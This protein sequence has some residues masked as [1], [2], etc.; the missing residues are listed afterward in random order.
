ME[1]HG[2]YI[3]DRQPGLKDQGKTVA[4][5]LST[6]GTH[7]IHAGFAAR[8]HNRRLGQDRDK[9]AVLFHEDNGPDATA[10]SKE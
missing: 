5:V 8:G 7:L 9:F 4:R 2:F 6:I 3:H 10:I 1:L